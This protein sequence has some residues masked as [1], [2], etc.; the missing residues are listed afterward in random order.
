MVDVRVLSLPVYSA[1]SPKTKNDVVR[2]HEPG[3]IYQNIYLRVGVFVVQHYDDGG[4][5]NNRSIYYITAARSSS[6][7]LLL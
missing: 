3:I 1:P 4:T 7:L 2:Y 5:I 6:I